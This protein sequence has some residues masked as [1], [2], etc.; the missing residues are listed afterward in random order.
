MSKRISRP[1]N[2]RIK[3]YYT[4]HMFSVL[5]RLDVPTY[6]DPLVQRQLEQA[7]PSNSRQTVIWR[8]VVGVINMGSTAIMLLSQLSVLS[9]VLKN[10]QDGTLIAI[11]SFSHS[12]LSSSSDTQSL[13]TRGM[14]LF[15]F[16]FKG[17]T[18]AQYGLLLPTMLTLSNCLVSGRL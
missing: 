13:F 8:T 17:M 9:N 12:I 3:Q 18:F 15:S 4:V 6:D 1:L 11:L 5:A 10:Q 2:A 16:G 14:L 7:F